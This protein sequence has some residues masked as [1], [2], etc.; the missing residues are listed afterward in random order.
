[1]WGFCPNNTNDLDLQVARND[2]D[3]KNVIIPASQAAISQ[4]L[5][6]SPVANCTKVSCHPL[7]DKLYETLPA[8]K[9]HKL[10]NTPGLLYY[11]SPLCDGVISQSI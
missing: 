7:S 6:D 3:F 2:A 1:M 11:T 5:Y 9:C 4:A 8:M 10:T